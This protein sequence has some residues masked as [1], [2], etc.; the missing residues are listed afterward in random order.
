MIIHRSEPVSNFTI[1]PNATLRDPKLSYQA[2]GILAELLSRPAD[3]A[4]TADAMSRNA[5]D[6]RGEAGEGRDVLR[7]AFAELASVGYLYRERRRGG[8]G[9]F[10]T[11]LHIFDTPELLK[12]WLAAEEW[13]AAV[14]NSPSENISAGRTDDGKGSRRSG[15]E[16]GATSQVAPTTDLPGVGLPGVGPPGVGPPGVFTKTDNEDL[17]TK[18]ENEDHG[19]ENHVGVLTSPVPVES[20]HARSSQK[21]LSDEEWAERERIAARQVGPLPEVAP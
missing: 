2:R 6:E 13:A 5:K 15:L 9:R 8:R 10:R 1:I 21:R 14:D 12:A 20:E 4:T 7:A 16:K 19:H 17:K 18:T 11:M 3:W